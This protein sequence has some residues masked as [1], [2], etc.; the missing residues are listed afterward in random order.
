MAFDVEG[1]VDRSMG[2]K[3]SLGRS[4]RLEPL[5]LAL[6]PPRRLMGVLGPIV[7]TL[8]LIVPNPQSKLP[9]CSA[10]GPQLV[11]DDRLWS[12]PM[13]PEQFAHQPQSR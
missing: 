7:P 3:K 5:H 1:V 4:G 13:F 11:G 6:T 10:V 8:P 12:E 9:E 2:G